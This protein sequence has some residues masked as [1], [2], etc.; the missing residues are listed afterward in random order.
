MRTRTVR[1]RWNHGQDRQGAVSMGNEP[2]WPSQASSDRASEWHTCPR[3]SSIL[4]PSIGGSSPDGD[5]STYDEIPAPM[6]RMFSAHAMRR[7]DSRH[8]Q[9]L[10]NKKEKKMILRRSLTKLSSHA[11][12]TDAGQRDH[13]KFLSIG[14]LPAAPLRKPRW[15][16]FLRLARD[17]SEGVFDQVAPRFIDLLRRLHRIQK[18]L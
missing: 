4:R 16:R 10:G 8:C 9:M 6:F 5:R 2:T 7:D 11:T 17:P 13:S 12:R 3:R 1:V 18:P 15:H 14:Q